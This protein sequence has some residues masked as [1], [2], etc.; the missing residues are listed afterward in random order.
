MK[1]LNI[2]LSWQIVL[3]AILAVMVGRLFPA[4]TGFAGEVA[5]AY[6]RLLMLLLIPFFFCAIMSAFTSTDDNGFALR[7]TLKNLTIF[8]VM[9]VIAVSTAL[10]VSN[11][12]FAY[13]SPEVPS[14]PAAVL[15]APRSFG[16]FLFDMV[17]HSFED[18]VRTKNL[19]GIIIIASVVGYYA[20]RCNDKSRLYLANMFAACN[21]L[22]MRLAGFVA[23]LSPIGI[24]CITCKLTAESEVF[25]SLQKVKPLVIAAG[26]A[27]ALHSFVLVPLMLK[28]FAKCHPYRLLKMFGSILWTSLGFSTSTLVSTLAICRMK[29]E[30]GVSPRIADCTMPMLTVLNFNGSSIFLTTAILY[31]AQSYSIDLSFLEQVILIFTVSFITIGTVSFPLKLSAI[32]FPVMESLGVPIEGMGVIVV[33]DLLFGMFCS[34]ADTWCNISATALIANTE[35][36]KLKA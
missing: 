11:I 16:D 24:F 1:N 6:L 29:S 12:F 26:I 7:I 13:T 3:A 20:N 34:A 30:S 28:S 10:I 14:L 9:E 19:P 5:E 15:D 32:I 27:L 4:M 35:G 17:P 23:A 31:V 18:V 21:E 33:C 36:D 22:M 8:V 25:D 2:P